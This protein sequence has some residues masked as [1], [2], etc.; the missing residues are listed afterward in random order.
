MVQSMKETLMHHDT[1]DII[2][3]VFGAVELSRT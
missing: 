1:H 2:I 3:G